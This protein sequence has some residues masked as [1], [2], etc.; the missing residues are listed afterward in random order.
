VT[1]EEQLSAIARARDAARASIEDLERILGVVPAFAAALRFTEA[2][3]ALDRLAV[4]V[5]RRAARMA[6]GNQ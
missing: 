5:S 4:V 3:D 6:G 2:L 1:H